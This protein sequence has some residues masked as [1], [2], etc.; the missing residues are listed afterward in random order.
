MLIKPLSKELTHFIASLRRESAIGDFTKIRKRLCDFMTVLHA[1]VLLPICEDCYSSRIHLLELPIELPH[2][3]SDTWQEDLAWEVGL[4][5]EEIK[6]IEKGTREDG[7]LEIFCNQCNRLLRY[8]HDDFYVESELFEEYFDI[9]DLRHRRPSRKLRKEIARLY[10][11]K[12]YGCGKKLLREDISNDHIVARVH[13]GLTS[14]LNLQILC[15]NCDNSVKG[16]RKVESI[17]VNLTF[18]FRPPPSD[19]Y[20]GAIW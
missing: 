17:N 10:G 5:E 18:L 3:C 13:G 12:C 7:G 9:P 8:G 6:E 2:I 1:K 15:R 19:S 20:E 11:H 16:G 14:P 4:D